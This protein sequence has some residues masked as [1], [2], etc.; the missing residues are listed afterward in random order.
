MRRAGFSLIELV[1]VVAVL[2]IMF[3]MIRIPWGSLF[4]KNDKTMV[5]GRIGERIY[6]AY[7]KAASGTFLEEGGDMVPAG[8]FF[9]ENKITS[10]VGEAYL[11]GSIEN[12]EYLLSSGWQVVNV[13]FLNST[14]LFV[15]GSGEVFNW[16]TESSGFSILNTGTGE[17]FSYEINNWGVLNEV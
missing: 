11:P 6:T 9:E 14:L 12:E 4:V 15:A 16:A 13:E 2:G 17:V 7:V 5:A 10:F 8:V 3:S 1:I